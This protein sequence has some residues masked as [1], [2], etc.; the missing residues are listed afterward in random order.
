MTAAVLPFTESEPAPWIFD[1]IHTQR[2]GTPKP[3]PS[4]RTIAIARRATG[5]RSVSLLLSSLSAT[6][7]P[8]REGSHTAGHETNAMTSGP[9]TQPS[10]RPRPGLPPGPYLVVGLARSGQ[11]AARLL[12]S[13][14]ETVVGC[15]SGSPDGLEGLRA[16]GV[17]VHLDTDGVPLLE[18][19]R[20]L[21]KSPGVPREAPVVRSAGERGIPVLGELELAW[22]VIPNRFVA[23]TGTNGKTTVTELL[24]QVWRT[25]AEPIAVAGNV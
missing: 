22:R 21:V 20:C 8:H 9:P 2:S 25:A 10:Q 12:A 5:A 16:A 14:S 17:E 18:R 15:D 11:A 19:T 4:A 6:V 24:G 13:R 3:T 1:P 23:V 7:G